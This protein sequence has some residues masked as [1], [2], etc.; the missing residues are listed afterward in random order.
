MVAGVRFV[1]SSPD[2]RQSSLRSGRIPLSD[3]ADF[4]GHLL[5]GRHKLNAGCR[6]RSASTLD[7]TPNC[8]MARRHRR[9]RPVDFD[10][11]AARPLLPLC[12]L[13]NT[14]IKLPVCHGVVMDEIITPRSIERA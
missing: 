5:V 10:L 8:E 13:N 1:M 6:D 7:T 12:P 4:P 9:L 14:P 11:A 2:W 3:C